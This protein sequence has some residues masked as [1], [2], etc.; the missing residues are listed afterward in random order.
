MFYV[1]KI[2][3]NI[4][5]SR[6]WWIGGGAQIRAEEPYSEW[7]V[8][9][10]HLTG[11]SRGRWGRRCSRCLR[12]GLRQVLY[13]VS[14]G[15]GAAATPSPLPHY[16]SLTLHSS[17]TLISPQPQKRVHFT[18]PCPQQSNNLPAH[19][20]PPPSTASLHFTIATIALRS[21]GWGTGPLDSSWI[22]LCWALGWRDLVLF[23]YFQSWTHSCRSGT[24]LFKKSA[25]LSPS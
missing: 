22:L 16:S 7:D 5:T 18:E 24:F 11:W 1:E 3:L 9:Q 8:G 4:C 15:D 10:G 17:H 19:H 20:P 13:A 12:N 21:W 25:K 23:C 6:I 2:T 14:D